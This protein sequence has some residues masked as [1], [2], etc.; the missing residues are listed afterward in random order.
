VKTAADAMRVSVLGPLEVSD[1]AG[2][3]VRVGGHRVR[4]L[5]ILLAL[6]AGRVLP[7][8]ALIERL[9]PED[10]EERPADA[11]NALQSLVSRLRVALR[12]AGIPEGVLE[13]ATSGYRLAVPPGAVDAIAFEEQARAG[14]QAL[15]RG[16]A[17]QAASL[18]GNALNQWRGSALTDV[19]REEF[20]VAPV[21]RLAEL[22]AAATLDRIEADLT[23]DAANA[24]IIGELR[25]LTAA[26]PLQE[27]QAALLMRAL[28]ATGRQSEA[29]SVYQKTRGQLADL[30][31]VDPSHQLEQAYLAILRQEIPPAAVSLP[32]TPDTLDTRGTPAAASQARPPHPE[33]GPHAAKIVRRPPTSFVGRDDDVAGVLKRLRTERLVTLTGP[34]GVGKTRLA[35]ETAAKLTVPAWFAELAP[36]TD[37]AEVPYAVLDALGLRERSI[38]PRGAD[39]AGDPLD[40]LCGALNDRDAVL[41]LDNCEHVIDDAATLAARLLSDCPKVK[42]L[43]T[44]REPLQ[45]HGETLH[46][47]APLPAPKEADIPEI[48]GIYPAVRL[49]KD[50][51]AA[52][53]P[54]FELSKDNA[55][56]VAS[57]CRNLDGMPLAIEL[58][59][60]WLRTLTPA[61]LA[62]RLGDRFALLTGGS[63]TALPRHQTLRAVVD[64]SWD[65]LSERERVL[66]RRLA[67]FPGGATLT[68]AERVCA[69][70]SGQEGSPLPASA[71][72]PTLAGLV[73]KSLLTR[74]DTG[75]AS[76]PRYRMLDT[77]RAY[78]LDRLA[79]ASEHTATRDAA[80]RYYL[81]FA[82]IADPQLRTKTQA[83]WFRAV[84]AEQDNVNAAIRWAI[85]QGDADTA[86]RFVRALGYYWIQ[87]G[88]GEADAL[89]RDVLAMTPPPLTQQLAEARVI[90]A[91]LAAGWTW[92]IDR[93]REP[94]IEALSALAG[95]GAD[96]GS[97]HP[98][99]TMAE[100]MLSQYDGVTER[101]LQQFERYMTARDPWLRG[102]GKVSYS[103]YAMSL[104]TLDG[105]EELCRVGLAEL[106]ALGE[107]WGVAMALT[108]LAEFTEL[109]ADHATS[110]A[111]I[112]EAAA[113]GR[114]IG[115][116]G[117]LTYVEGRLAVVHARAGDL[118]RGYAE[119][120]RVRRSIE[121]RGGHVDTDRWVSFMLAELASRAGDYAEAA[122]CCEAVLT[123]I[124]PNEAR[125]WQSLRAQVKARLAIALLK[126]GHQKRCVQLLTES[127][128]AAAAWWEHP[129]LATVLDAC[130]VYALTRDKEGDAERSACLLGAAHAIRGAFDESSLDAP[131]ARA[132][133]R[134]TLG[135]DAFDAAYESTLTS[136]YESA[137]ALAR[138]LLTG[139][140]AAD[141]RPEAA[142]S[143]RTNHFCVPGA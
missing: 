138:D 61:Q 129:A 42:L 136:T 82:E 19:A 143:A 18:L 111:A 84:T 43:A 110:I 71:V 14:S 70:Q 93:V 41:I 89:S 76:E 49:F 88:H 47:V 73:S 24:T 135:P 132:A 114:E 137:L 75:D 105:A 139:L 90:C 16:D 96:Y 80:A 121:A 28:A 78:G 95:F 112:T 62:A 54:G 1:A 127:L 30:L 64:W 100:P 29:L 13:S 46:I 124:A 77:V 101:A 103:S 104:G 56:A 131:P 133:A 120:A 116:W 25:E 15:A 126:Q 12:Q 38:A 44:S 21:A 32:D 63:R 117:D 3:P 113:I 20:A 2:R 4:A 107:R 57:I 142:Q 8:H 85:A 119:I 26:D 27:R 94:L 74:V 5:L 128:D 33:R 98:L 9:W 91:L 99:V 11:A 6:D 86:L 34:G 81:E 51:A 22:R 72:L 140:V 125:W 50:R 23:L 60:P 69:A 40:R 102:I 67:V 123:T 31:G 37:P 10:R 108:V 45:I 53:L 87:R 59:A 106:R 122:R 83:H 134:A 48:S 141:S 52:V 39:M 97:V 7:A 115:V 17:R 79:E 66:T 130:A 65:L 118:D 68:A 35:A 36:V 92:D 109:R 55:E 58:A